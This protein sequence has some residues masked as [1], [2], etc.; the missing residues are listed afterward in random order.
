[1][2]R[3]DLTHPINEGRA[4]FRSRMGAELAPVLESL[5]VERGLV[6][7]QGGTPARV[8]GAAPA[9]GARAELPAPPP[10]G[11][12]LAPPAPMAPPPPLPTLPA[13]PSRPAVAPLASPAP[14]SVTTSASSVAARPPSGR[15]APAAMTA[16]A[17]DGASPLAPPPASPQRPEPRER[18][19]WMQSL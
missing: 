9:A 4:L 19:H 10:S 12:A 6:P 5:L 8:P 1:G 2:R 7:S 15:F 16:P 17:G 3:G 18:A 11:S 14:G 13:P